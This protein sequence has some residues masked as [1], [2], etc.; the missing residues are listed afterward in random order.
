MAK[1]KRK[2]VRRHVSRGIAH[3][4]ATFNNTTV[5][6]TDLNG[7]VLCWVY[8]YS[9]Y[10][11]GLPT[12]WYLSEIANAAAKAGAPDDYVQ[13]LRSRPTRDHAEE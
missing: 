10:E 12:E 7:E 1:S 13:D 9:G 2:K 6:I 11:G 4:K 3:I 5:T 8:V